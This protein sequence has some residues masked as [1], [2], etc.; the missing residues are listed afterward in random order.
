MEK[1]NLYILMEII[2]KDSGSKI[3]PM[4]MEFIYKKKEENIK[5]TGKTMNLMDSELNN[6]AME[7]YIKDNL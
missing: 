3:K 5:E 6:G 2:M 7:T 1:V 4:D